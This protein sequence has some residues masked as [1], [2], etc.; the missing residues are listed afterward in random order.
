MSCYGCRTVETATPAICQ[1]ADRVSLPFHA[2]TY[3]RGFQLLEVV[4]V[5]TS[6]TLYRSEL[7]NVRQNRIALRY[8]YKEINRKDGAVRR[9][10]RGLCALCVDTCMQTDTSAYV[11]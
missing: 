8:S 9:L 1:H 2:R 4:L 5:L 6:F 11:H 3:H 7:S 10:A